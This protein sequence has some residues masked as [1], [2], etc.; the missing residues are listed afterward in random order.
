[1]AS[2]D[3]LS[4]SFHA[5]GG[6][7]HVRIAARGQRLLRRA[8]AAV[9]AEVQRLEAKYSIYRADSV[10]SRINATAGSGQAVAVDAETAAL[11][12]FAGHLHAVSGGRFDVT[13]GALRRCWNFAGQEIPDAKCLRQALTCVGWQRLRWQGG[14]I[15]LPLCGM[16]LDFGG[17]VKEYAADRAVMV[18]RQHG[19]NHGYV[20]LAGDMALAGPRPDGQPWILAIRHPR[21]PDSVAMELSLQG[22]AL[23]TSGDYERF[24]DVG[25]RRFCHI[26]DART[27]WPPEC[28]QSVSVIAPSCAAAGALATVAFLLAEQGPTF[29]KQQGVLH[30]CLGSSADNISLKS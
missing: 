16:A 17:I 9:Q 14:H 10:L 27:G 20:N 7:N 4:A 26:L 29:L 12:D 21:R 8:L 6:P 25:G 23:A 30:A 13:S 24:M 3:E 5:M 11:L 22:G 18:L 2:W 1:M 15:T 19:V 28:W